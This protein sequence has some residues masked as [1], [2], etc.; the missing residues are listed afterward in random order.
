[1]TINSFGDQKK[2]K[3]FKEKQTSQ[4][5]NLNLEIEGKRYN[6]EQ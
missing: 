1:M 2:E 4:Q 5:I 6:S 3:S